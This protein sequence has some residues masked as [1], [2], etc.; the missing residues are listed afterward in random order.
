MLYRWQNEAVEGKSPL[1]QL[2]YQSRLV[3]AE[4]ALVLWGG[5]NNSIKEMGS[6]PLGQP[7]PVM[8]IKGSGSD[9]KSILAGEYPAVRLDYVLPLQERSAMSDD[10]MVAYLARCLMDPTSPRPSIETLLH[11]FLPHRAVLHTHADA[12]LAITNNQGR[13]RTVRDCFGNNVVL[14]PYLRPGFELSRQVGLLARRQPEAE[15]LILMNHGLITWGDTPQAAYE[16]HIELVTRAE[17]FIKQQRTIQP[18]ARTA[19]QDQTEGIVHERH[20]RAAAIAPVLRGLLGQEKQVVLRYDDSPETLGFLGRR[21]IAR[22]TQIGAATPDHLLHTKR[23]P[24]VVNIEAGLPKAAQREAIRVALEQYAM[25]YRS[26]FEKYALPGEKMLESKPRVVLVPGVGMWTAGKDARAAQVVADIY[27]HTMKIISDAEVLGGY[28]TL[29]DKDAFEG[30]YWPL[31]LY[32][33]TLLPKE[34]DLARK[35]ALVTGAASGIGRAI[36]LRFA[37]EGAHVVVTDLNVEGARAVAQ[38]ICQ[39]QGLNRATGLELNVTSPA[40][41]A[42]ALAA[43]CR[44]YGGLDI[45][46]S[47]AGVAFVGAIDQLD[48]EQWEKSLAV[49]TTGHFLVVRAALEIMKAQGTGGSIVFNATKNVTAPGKDF[50]AYSVSKAAEAQLC[51]IVA[52]EAADFGIRAN[53]LNPDAIF[54]GSQLWS[55]ELRQQRAQA[56]GLNVEE[57]PDFYRKRNLLKAE[58]TSADVAEAA[59]FLASNRSGKTTG[60]MLP[61]DGGVKE[62]FPR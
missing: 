29:N 27:R 9:M 19:V 7:L 47:N 49:N 45:L 10:E 20:N 50:G 16:K 54:E 23:F 18:A 55:E 15:G 40:S 30:E 41:V 11:A 44:A 14:V 13:E 2:V 36:A 37:E 35:V 31:E 62:A 26:Y 33:L 32:K 12:I 53:M 46:V 48:L 21:D 3:G 5:G 61:V 60:A 28:A 43:T 39:K 6:D 42:E 52:I 1:E 56:Y 51:R 24:L 4:D 25:D 22:L 59:L 58:V 8:Y 17:E 38:E 34:K 57:L